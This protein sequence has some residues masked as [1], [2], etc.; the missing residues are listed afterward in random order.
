M[1]SY[2]SNFNTIKYDINGDGIFDNIVNLTN[3]VKMTDKLSDDVSLY[4][5]VDINSGER[6]DQLSY[7][8]YGSTKYYWT[9]LLTNPNIK[10][11]WNDWPKTDT[12][13]LE[14]VTTKYEGLSACTNFDLTNKFELGE[15]VQGV[16]SGAIGTVHEI[17]VN[18]GYIHI[19]PVSGTFKED[20]EDIIGLH[21]QDVVTGESIRNVGYAPK[22]H[23]DDATGEITSKRLAGTTPV[24][25]LDF[26]RNHNNRNM[27]IKVIKPEHIQDIFEEFVI[28]IAK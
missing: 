20:G 25:I 13:L 24:T 9:F 7:R 12:Q 14:Y 27:H 10:N 26:E 17:H 2:F 11:F 6:P 1:S 16:I 5:F 23:I 21:T 4:N 8:L 3:I 15:Q 28:E 19:L 18:L 22:Y